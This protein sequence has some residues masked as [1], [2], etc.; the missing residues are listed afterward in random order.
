M[1]GKQIEWLFCLCVLMIG[2]AIGGSLVHWYA[3]NTAI[4]HGAAEWR[5][6]SKTGVTS[7]HW[8]E[9]SDAR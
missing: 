7:F 9:D 2:I 1:N 6:D 3:Q 5:I 8:L 4:E